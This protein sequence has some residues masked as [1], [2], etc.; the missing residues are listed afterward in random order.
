M[1]KS[2]ENSNGHL[3]SNLIDSF[4]SIFYEVTSSSNEVDN[5]ESNDVP[6]FVFTANS[7]SI[8]NRRKNAMSFTNHL[9]DNRVCHSCTKTSNQLSAL[10]EAEEIRQRIEYIKLQILNRIGLKEPPKLRDHPD[11]DLTLCNSNDHFVNF[12]FKFNIVSS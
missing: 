2:D 7:A 3:V 5:S 11:I 8:S 10:S 9:K 12:S 4:K 1:S 6:N